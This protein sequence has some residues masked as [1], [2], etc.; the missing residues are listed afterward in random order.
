V[1]AEHE[2]DPGAIRAWITYDWA[3]SAYA[4][5]ILGA[6]LPAYFAGQ[7][8]GD[9]GVELFGRNWIGQDLWALAV[10]VGPLIMFLVTP[11]LGAIA[12]FSAAKKRF[13]TVFAIWGASYTTLLF[14]A[15]TGDVLLTLG[16]FLLAHLG[17]V[18]ANVFYDAYLPDLTSDETIDMVSSRGFAW[19]YLGGGIHLLLS[20]ALI[21]LSDGVMPIDTAL[22]TR[23]AIGSVGLWWL[24]FAVL[25]FRGLPDVGTSQPLADHRTPTWWGYAR[26]GFRRTLATLRKVARNRPL[27]VF[28][29]AFMLFNDGVQTTI[30]LAAVYATET[31][32]LD[33]TMV[34]G[35][36][37]VVQF[38]AF[39]GA[40]GFGRLASRIGT[41][42]ALLASIVIW[43]GVTLAAFFLPVGQAVPFLALAVVI[44]LVLGG[45]QA[46]S[47]SLYGSMIPEEQS[48]EFYGFYSVFSKFSSIWGPFAFAFVRQV[49]GSAR[50]AILSIALFF[51]VGGLL[52][53]TVD[54]E[55]GRQTRE[56][57]RTPAQVT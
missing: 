33:I 46:L 18:G 16:L 15:R 13:L 52:F 4:T 55:K 38:I 53:R 31:L 5:T 56:Q 10:G 23:I 9:E 19:G 37:L 25:S 20:L 17:F 40:M 6:V 21:Q 30:A 3:N 11:V 12:D 54:I 50:L 41:R 27:L 36:V 1:A 48:A 51:I 42:R 47:R 57:L 34:I 26:F 49:T 44:G 28:I 2:N 7:V 8:V 39:F 45:T 35:G 29:V 32:G 22:A 14:F 43:A 24:L